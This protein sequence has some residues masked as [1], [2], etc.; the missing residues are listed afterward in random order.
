MTPTNQALGVTIRFLRLRMPRLASQR[1]SRK[2]KL[3][4]LQNFFLIGGAFCDPREYFFVLNDKYGGTIFEVEKVLGE[5]KKAHGLDES[6]CYLSRDL[7]DEFIKLDEDMI[8]MVVGGIPSID[9]SDYLDYSVLGSVITHILETPSP[10]GSSSKLVSPDFDQ[11]ILFNDLVCNGDWLR[12]KQ[13]EVWQIDDYY[14]RNSNF[15]KQILRDSLAAYY[16][17]SIAMIPSSTG[18]SSAGDLRFAYILEKIAPRNNSVI[19]D[20][21]RKDA[22]LVLMSKY[23]ETCDIFEEPTSATSS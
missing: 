10:Y 11:K 2:F 19:M 8:F 17:E 1:P 22:A 13:R 5:I 3:I 14:S 6:K 12:A 21:L 15:A 4:S 9:S 23:F 7:E 16:A 18:D 20:R